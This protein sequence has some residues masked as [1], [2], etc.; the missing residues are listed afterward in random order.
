M[1][2]RERS[3]CS[4]KCLSRR[5]ADKFAKIML[6]YQKITDFLEGCVDGHGLVALKD[7][8]GKRDSPEDLARFLGF[9]KHDLLISSPGLRLKLANLLR[10]SLPLPSASLEN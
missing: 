10:K 9:L 3:D 7:L 4:S 5:L 6:S 1:A 2:K 8:L